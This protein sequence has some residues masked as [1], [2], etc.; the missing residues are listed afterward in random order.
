MFSHKNSIF[1]DWKYWTWN[2][3]GAMCETKEAIL[4]ADHWRKQGKT[5]WWEYCYCLKSIYWMQYISNSALPFGA[6]KRDDAQSRGSATRFLG[7]SV[8]PLMDS[9]QV[10][11]SLCVSLSWPINSNSN[12]LLFFSLAVKLDLPLLTKYFDILKWEYGWV[13]CI[14]TLHCQLPESRRG[15]QE[16]DHMILLLL[17]IYFLTPTASKQFCA[18]PFILYLTKIIIPF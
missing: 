8:L 10:L 4:C 13:G 12:N 18:R 6:R 7:F 15:S 14:F 1:P 17:L 5:L 9:R 16:K 11:S 2:G 3:K